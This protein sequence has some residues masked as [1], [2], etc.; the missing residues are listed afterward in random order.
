VG[1]IRAIFEAL[2]ADIATEVARP[3]N[4]DG[5]GGTP[6]AVDVEIGLPKTRNLPGANGRVVLTIGEGGE[7]AGPKAMNGRLRTL[8][9]WSPALAAH[10]WVPV[11]Q[12]GA[13]DELTRIDS[14]EAM[15]KCV[16]RAI[17]AGNH[18]ATIPDRPPVD[19]AQII[20]EPA[21]MRHGESAIVTFAVGV[22]IAKGRTLTTLP[23]GTSLAANLRVNPES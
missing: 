16:V 10:L 15:I 11:G 12:A 9:T 14:I 22:P 3:A 18:G 21:V 4:A 13:R 1:S 17:Y 5:T 23:A 6:F 20:T 2:E 8:C 7:V 19:G